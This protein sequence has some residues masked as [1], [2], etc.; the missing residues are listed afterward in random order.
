MALIAHLKEAWQAQ[1]EP[2]LQKASV[3]ADALSNKN[4]EGVA[5][6]NAVLNI[7]SVSG[8]EAEAWDGNAWTDADWPDLDTT[9]QTLT[10][11][12]KTT[13]KF[14]VPR[15]SEQGSA[16]NLLQQGSE[17]AAY[18]VRD[19]LDMFLASL[20]T[21]ITSNLYGS[22]AEPI[23]VG[24]GLNDVSPLTFLARLQGAL[25]SG[26][27]DQSAP[28]VVIPVWYGEMLIKELGNRPSSLGDNSISQGVV[29]GLFLQ[30]VGGFKQV[31]CSNNVADT[32][33]AL[34]KV[35]AGTPKSSITL[36]RQLEEIDVVD[37]QNH[38]AKG[39]KGLY[40]YGGKIP[41]QGHMALGTANQGSWT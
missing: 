8:V 39:V 3:Y 21:Q 28:N 37:L 34:Y 26:N 19:T 22:D 15:V 13:F 1:I 6:E 4:Y 33:D 40:I 41:F 25:A 11:D 5:R 7:I 10:C 14:R 24:F 35:M 32:G 31:Y 20:H 16:V 38:F 27:A 30:N 29:Q 18:E 2:L 36:A 9:G 23:T 17:L 12:Q